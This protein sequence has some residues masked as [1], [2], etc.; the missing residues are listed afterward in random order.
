MSVLDEFK[1]FITRGNVLDLAVAVVIGLAF[2]AVINAL[3]AD[4][5][6]PLIGIFGSHD[7]SAYQSTVGQGVFTW[8]H[9]LTAVINFILIALVVFFLLVRPAAKMAERR[10]AAQAAA[11]AA[12]EV[13]TRDCPE[14]LSKVPLKATR[15]AYCTS[16]LPPA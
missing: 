16:S 8:G 3:V 12:A 2:Q 11:Q 13:T 5:I 4:L 1:A 7:L 15:C 14:C 9:F 6:N 10:A